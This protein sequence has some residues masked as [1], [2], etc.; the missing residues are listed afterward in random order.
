[1]QFIVT[2]L[3]FTVARYRRGAVLA[4]VRQAGGQRRTAVFSAIGVVP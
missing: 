3:S 1:M 4:K 2:S